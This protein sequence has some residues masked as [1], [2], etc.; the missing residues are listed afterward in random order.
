MNSANKASNSSI[1]CD[2]SE[3]VHHNNIKNACSL[4]SINVGTCGPATNDNACTQCD[5][6]R[7]K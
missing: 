1:G 3:C 6:Y 4:H 7:K 2:V 5:S